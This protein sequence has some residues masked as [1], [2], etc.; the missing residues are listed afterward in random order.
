MRDVG[1][2]GEDVTSDG[3]GLCSWEALKSLT[4]EATCGY[5]QQ[6]EQQVSPWKWILEVHLHCSHS[7]HPM[8]LRSTS[9]CMFGEQL[10]QNSSGHLSE[11]KL[12]TRLMT[13]TLVPG[14]AGRSGP[15]LLFIFLHF[16]LA[17][18]DHQSPRMLAFVAHLAAWPRSSPLRPMSTC[19]VALLLTGWP[20]LSPVSLHWQLGQGVTRKHSGQSHGSSTQSSVL[21]L[22]KWPCFL[23]MITVSYSCQGGDPLSGVAYNSMGHHCVPGEIVPSLEKMMSCRAQRCWN[24]EHRRPS[25]SLWIMVGAWK[26]LIPLLGSQ[27]FYLTGTQ[28]HIKMDNSGYIQD[29]GGWSIASELVLQQLV[30]TLCQA[31]RLWVIKYGL[32]PVDPMIKD[33]FPYHLC[34][35]KISLGGITKQEH[36]HYKP[37][38]SGAAEALQAERQTHTQNKYLFI[39]KYLFPWKWGT[40]LSRLEGAQHSQHATKR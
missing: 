13:Q 23:L 30:P 6:A 8:P 26:C 14:A 4:Q 35:K 40:G 2:S 39:N 18:A 28:Y 36:K 31:H 16:H 20:Y 29:A 7:P 19:H 17:Q 34:Y 5:S 25:E 24:G 3:E 21:P 12:R 27:V 37:L 1:Y 32:W 38:D 15:Q 9:L 11:G 10:L 33:P 22:C